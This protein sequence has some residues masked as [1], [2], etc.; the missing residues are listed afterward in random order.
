MNG[1][2]VRKVALAEESRS[3]AQEIAPGPHEIAN[4]EIETDEHYER[5]KPLIPHS[6]DDA[7]C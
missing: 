1:I 2:G 3:P 4:G 6:P 7:P 5:D